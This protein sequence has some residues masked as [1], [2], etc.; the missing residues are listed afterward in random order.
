MTGNKMLYNYEYNRWCV[1]TYGIEDVEGP[2][3]QA[4]REIVER[5]L[6]LGLSAESHDDC[7]A[8]LLR[9]FEELTKEGDDS[10]P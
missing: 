5:V 4:M 6:D 2:R 8:S 1:E 10:E 3:L 7:V 9:K